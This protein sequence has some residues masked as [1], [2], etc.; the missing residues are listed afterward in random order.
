MERRISSGSM[1]AALIPFVLG[2]AC[3]E[4]AVVMQVDLLSFIGASERAPHH[5][6]VPAGS[7]LAEPITIEPQAVELARG[8]DSVVEVGA[9]EIELDLE[10]DNR[11]AAGSAQLRLYVTAG[12]E[13][14]GTVH[15]YDTAPVVAAV[16]ALPAGAAV[17]HRIA[18]DSRAAPGL[19]GAF[20]S[21]AVIV[22]L[23]IF[24]DALGATENVEGSWTMTGFRA[25]VHGQGQ[26]SP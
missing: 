7:V 12:G 13:G 24:M 2:A 21:N 25:L 14:P 8:L 17:E 22:G 10:F 6:H 3:G 11:G 20:E 16:I 1:V 23:A 9:A 4:R 18:V 5:Y 26:L 19:I 15:V